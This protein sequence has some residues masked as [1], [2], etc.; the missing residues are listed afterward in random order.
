MDYL[1]KLNEKLKNYISLISC[2]FIKVSQRKYTSKKTLIN[3]PGIFWSNDTFSKEVNFYLMTQLKKYFFHEK[4]LRKGW[5][6]YTN[7]EEALEKL[8]SHSS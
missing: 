6:G 8:M 4:K 3:D 5:I 1:E 7:S 2:A